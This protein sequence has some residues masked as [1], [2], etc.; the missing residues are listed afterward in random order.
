MKSSFGSSIADDEDGSSELSLEAEP[1]GIEFMAAL[2]A[3]CS[4]MDS[5]SRLNCIKDDV[6]ID[7]VIS[8]PIE[9]NCPRWLLLV[10][11]SQ[12]LASEAS[13]VT[14]PDPGA[15]PKSTDLLELEPRDDLDSTS[16]LLLVDDIFFSIIAE[17]VV[18]DVFGG[19]LEVGEEFSLFSLFSRTC[20]TII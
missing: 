8:T 7:S 4:N 5:T 19:D 6:V 1:L 14:I 13:V 2:S 20:Q 18:V 10:L 12:S 16:N 17:V 3:P 15:G 11:D 9:A